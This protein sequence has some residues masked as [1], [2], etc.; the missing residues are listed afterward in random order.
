[1]FIIRLIF[2]FEILIWLLPPLKQYRGGLFYYFLIAGM[3]DPL[4]V[5]GVA[6]LRL[7]YNSV[8]IL[9]YFFQTL[10]VI[11]YNR[12]LT[13]GWIFLCVSI[14]ASSYYYLPPALMLI[15][16]VVFNLIIVYHLFCIFFN[17]IL[18]TKRINCYYFTFLFYELTLILKCLSVIYNYSGGIYYF[19]S[20][21]AI[22]IFIGFYFIFFN[23]DNSPGFKLTDT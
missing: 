3:T 9:S 22:E 5:L 18:R 23:L 10:S 17:D 2:Y 16:L 15:S 1:M 11:Y 19:Y 14:L 13:K 20:F 6:Y 12:K 4:S 21:T 8:Y 7:E